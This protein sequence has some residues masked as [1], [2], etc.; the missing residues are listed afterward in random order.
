MFYYLKL[1]NRELE[2]LGWLTNRGYFPAE[3]YDKLELIDDHDNQRDVE[4]TYRI[5]E[6]AAWSLSMLREDDP[7]AYL[8][9]LG[10]SLL[11]KILKLESEIV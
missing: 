3:L 1:T 7:D 5:P 10:G 8:T 11:D 2:D 9:C 6:H 4:Y